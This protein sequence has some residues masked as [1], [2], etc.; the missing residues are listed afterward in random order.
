MPRI[1]LGTWVIASNISNCFFGGGGALFYLRGKHS[2]KRGAGRI[3]LRGM[4]ACFGGGGGVTLVRQSSGKY[5]FS[6]FPVTLYSRG[7]HWHINYSSAGVTLVHQL[8]FSSSRPLSIVTT[9]H[10]IKIFSPYFL[11]FFSLKYNKA[12]LKASLLYFFFWIGSLS[13][14]SVFRTVYHVMSEPEYFINFLLY[15]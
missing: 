2:R 15:I 13:T 8:F 1:Y 3:L 9:I 10:F 7:F 14:L 12:L 11:N 4:P 5:S 6:G